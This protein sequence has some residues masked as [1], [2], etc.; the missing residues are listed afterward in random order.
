MLNVPRR[1]NCPPMP[2]PPRCSGKAI[3]DCSRLDNSIVKAKRLVELLEE[4]KQITSSFWAE[5]TAQDDTG[6]SG[7]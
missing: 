3:L 7:R 1:T 2:V 5:N 6:L 4:V